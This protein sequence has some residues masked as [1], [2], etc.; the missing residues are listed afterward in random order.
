MAFD[1][2]RDAG[3][4]LALRQV[5]DSVHSQL[6]LLST[7]GNTVCSTGIE[8]AATDPAGDGSF[9]ICAISGNC[10]AQARQALV[11]QPVPTPNSLII[12]L[13]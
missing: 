2:N 10:S 5:S 4:V 3:R 7:P 6:L 9:T 11:E 12:T 1:V 13:R 8:V